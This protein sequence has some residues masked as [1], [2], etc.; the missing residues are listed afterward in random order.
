MTAGLKNEYDDDSVAPRK[1]EGQKR[2]AQPKTIDTTCN[3]TLEPDA[4]A[5]VERDERGAEPDIRPIRSL[6]DTQGE[7]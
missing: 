4:T 7:D 3:A 6:N 5:L 2:K 1:P